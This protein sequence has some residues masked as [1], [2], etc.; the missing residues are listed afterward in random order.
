METEGSDRS[1]LTPAEAD[2]HHEAGDEEGT[3]TVRFGIIGAG[4][5]GAHHARGILAHRR[6]SVAW[7]ADPVRERGDALAAQ[8]GARHLTD[9][10]QALG[11]VQAVSICI[12]HAFL[13]EAA[14]AAAQAGAHILLEKPLALTL[15]DA[16]RVLEAARAADIRLM[17]GFVHRF[18]REAQRTFEL[19]KAGAIGEP[20]F[21]TDH[22]FAGGQASWPAWVQQTGSGGG[23]LLYSGVHRIDRARWLLGREVV[24]V[25]GSTAALLT[26][27]DVDSSFAA[28]LGFE[29]GPRAGIT[30]HYH[31]MP[32]RSMWE[33]VVH[34]T[35]GVIRML[36]GERLEI[37]DRRGT[38]TEA[39]G[40]DLHFEGEI[41]AFLDAIEGKP[42]AFPS[43]E[44]GRAVLAVALAI[45]QSNASGQIVAPSREK[46]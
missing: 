33:T 40:P 43:G 27:S 28:L 7:V 11:E 20:R 14:V 32:V 10:R 15:K 44:D 23:S 45:F 25:A 3:M 4:Q 37:I 17:I 1:A 24:T 8:C 31:T 21:V 22:S 39:A 12:P 9:Y 35:E 18:R 16:D 41:A 6:A 36:T 13:A 30:H 29:G 46:A 2:S 5:A 38:S 19:I 42:A 34:G 26:G